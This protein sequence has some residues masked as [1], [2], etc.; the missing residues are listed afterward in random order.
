MLSILA[1]MRT[2]TPLL[3]LALLDYSSAMRLDVPFQTTA[4]AA[5]MVGDPN[6]WSPKPTASPDMIKL[7]HG[8]YKI[9]DLKKRSVA[10][11]N[12]CGWVNGDIGKA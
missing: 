1:N 4:S 12:T 7:L 3:A 11:S 5:G 8:T 2:W 10:A 6:G 9:S